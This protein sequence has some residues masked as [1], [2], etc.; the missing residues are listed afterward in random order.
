[1]SICFIAAKYAVTSKLLRGTRTSLPKPPD[2]NGHV[3][4]VI[5]KSEVAIGGDV[6]TPDAYSISLRTGGIR[7]PRQATP[8][9]GIGVRLAA[10]KP[11][12][13]RFDL[14]RAS[15]LKA[16]IEFIDEN[17]GGPGVR[18]RKRQRA[19]YSNKPKNQLS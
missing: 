11:E 9:G 17:G 2:R 6:S 8:G 10:P 3:S 16:V 18:L 5:E 7:L 19:K 12:V 1:M 14:R 4:N 13:V 15:R